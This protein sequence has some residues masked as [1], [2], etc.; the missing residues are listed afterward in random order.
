[1]EGGGAIER[2]ITRSTAFPSA[3][4]LLRLFRTFL[5]VPCI[6]LPHVGLFPGNSLYHVHYI[7]A[8]ILLGLWFAL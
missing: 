3:F 7:I 8:C 6:Q 4:A 5:R 1:M 2:R